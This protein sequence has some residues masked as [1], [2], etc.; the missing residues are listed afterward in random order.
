VSMSEIG[1]DVV[2]PWSSSLPRR[3]DYAGHF[4]RERQLAETDPAQL[5]LAKETAGASAAEAPVTMPAAELCFLCGFRLSELFV[6]CDFRGGG[7]VSFFKA[8]ANALLV[9]RHPEMLQQRETFCVGLGAGRDANIHSLH[10]FDLVVVDL[11]ENQ[12]VFDTERVIATAIKR[13]TRY[14]AEVADTRQ[15]YVP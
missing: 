2:I 13:F 6:S 7:H 14:T 8:P 4:A 5:E 1:S 12:L 15:R 3:L 10:F 9:K 11:G